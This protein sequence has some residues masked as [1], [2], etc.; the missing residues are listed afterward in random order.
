MRLVHFV[1][2]KQRRTAAT[3]TSPMALSENAV[4]LITSAVGR[5]RCRILSTRDIDTFS[6]KG[7]IIRLVAGWFCFTHLHAVFSYG[8]QPNGSYMRYMRPTV[9]D[10][11]VQFRDS[12]SNRLRRRGRHF[13]SFFSNVDKCLAEVAGDVISCV[14]MD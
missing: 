1:A 5:W 12:R 11:Y 10:K 13:W 6:N 9:T 7:G 8:L 3:R 4:R 2:E 14:A